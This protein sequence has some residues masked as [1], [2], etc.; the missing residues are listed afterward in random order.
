MQAASFCGPLR[1]F[2]ILFLLQS[3][4]DEIHHTVCHWK[5]IFL[6]IKVL[7]KVHNYVSAVFKTLVGAHNTG[8]LLLCVIRWTLQAIACG[9]HMIEQCSIGIPVRTRNRLL[10]FINTFKGRRVGVSIMFCH[11]VLIIIK[12]S[13]H[14]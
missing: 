3:Q 12:T 13:L 11:E 14:L 8:E 6:Q 7:P 5:Y 2:I 10:A 1:I 9:L 4:N